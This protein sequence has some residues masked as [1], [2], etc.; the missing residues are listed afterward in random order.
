MGDGEGDGEISA[1]RRRPQ[2]CPK[3]GVKRTQPRMAKGRRFET[4]PLFLSFL[5][6]AAIATMQI[7]V[8]WLMQADTGNMHVLPRNLGTRSA[9]ESASATTEA[10]AG[11]DE[12]KASGV[13]C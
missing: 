10:I 11:L 7:R 8:L 5:G 13:S 6:R 4:E 1:R 3:Q 12:A 9:S 2:S